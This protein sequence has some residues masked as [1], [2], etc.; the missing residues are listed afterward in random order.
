[1]TDRC[2]KIF[3]VKNQC[4]DC[5]N[6]IYNTSPLSLLHQYSAIEK[7]KIKGLRISF[8][9]ESGKQIAEVMSYYEQGFIR[10]E[11]TDMDRYLKDFT[12]GHF[13]RGVE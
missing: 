1:M 11:K 13:K 4:R 3:T 12:N 8:T 5:Y 9:I 6:V 10:K 2:G 7:L